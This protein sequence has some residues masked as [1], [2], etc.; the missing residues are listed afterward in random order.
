MFAAV[1]MPLG[2]MA[3]AVV[4]KEDGLVAIVAPGVTVPIEPAASEPVGR[5]ALEEDGLGG[6]DELGGGKT[7]PH[8]DLCPRQERI[9]A[10]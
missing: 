10:R 4:A 8:F 1:E 2:L 5:V 6:R 7:D 9:A 3:H